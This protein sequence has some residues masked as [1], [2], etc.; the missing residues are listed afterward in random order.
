MQRTDTVIIGAGQCGLAMSHELSRRSID[1]V[2]IE[3]GRI[4]NSWLTGRWDSLR[5]LTPNWLNGLFGPVPGDPDGYMSAADF[6]STLAGAAAEIS[7]PVM[8]TTRV[9][10][11]RHGG[12]GY[13]VRTEQGTLSC[14]SLVLATGACALPRVPAFAS[15]LPKSVTQLTALSYRNPAQ[16]PDGS[17]VL[18]VGASASGLQIARELALSGHRVTLAVGQHTRL[19]RVHRGADIL[20]WMHL[21]GVL[22][23][24]FT[25]LDDLERMRRQ[26]S[27]ALLGDPDRVDLD[28]NTLQALGVEIAGR[29]VAVTE[30]RAWFSGSLANLCASSDL[31][32]RRLLD[33]IDAWIG[34]RGLQ[35]LVDPPEDIAPTRIPDDPILSLDLRARGIAAVIWATGYTPDH[36]FVDLPVFD[37]KGRIRHHGGRVG[38]GLYV[39]GLPYLR[40]ARSSH[41][42]GARRDARAIARDLIARPGWRAAA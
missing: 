11:V 35:A 9:T 22:D 8:E 7:A 32:M 24:P 12:D 26:P 5:L 18:V 31:K 14:A 2:V 27:L 13:V 10:S 4:G 20:T 38:N 29:L 25:R 15:G 28:L 40:T 36:S 34:A 16:L 41:V 37:R 33:R 3:R 23:T 1:H 42:S 39:M 19:P 6:A 17:A 30:G 21:V